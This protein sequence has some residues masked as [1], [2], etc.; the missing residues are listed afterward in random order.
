MAVAKYRQHRVALAFGILQKRGKCS[1]NGKKLSEEWQKKV[2]HSHFKVWLAAANAKIERRAEDGAEAS[3]ASPASTNRQNSEEPIEEEIED[4]NV[5]SSLGPLDPNA[6]AQ[7]KPQ[8]E[9]SQMQYDQ[10]KKNLM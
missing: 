2:K 6:N 10:I 1:G 7:R 5:D 4:G 9:G 3:P 8:N